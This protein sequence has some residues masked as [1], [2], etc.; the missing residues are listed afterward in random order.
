MTTNDR[1]HWT[2]AQATSIIMPLPCSQSLSDL[3][4]SF[5]HLSVIAAGHHWQVVGH[6]RLLHRVGQ[7]D[8]EDDDRTRH[9]AYDCILDLEIRN[10][11]ALEDAQ[12]LLHLD[13]RARAFSRGARHCMV[14]GSDGRAAYL[15]GVVEGV[16]P[17]LG[18]RRLDLDELRLFHQKLQLRRPA[19]VNLAAAAGLAIV[20]SPSRCREPH[21]IIDRSHALDDVLE[22]LELLGWKDDGDGGIV[23]VGLDRR[24]GVMLHLAEVRNDADWHLVQHLHLRLLDLKA[25]GRLALL[26]LELQLNVLRP[27]R[28]ARAER[29]RQIVHLD[30][31]GDLV[32]DRLALYQVF[33]EHGL[34]VHLTAHV[35]TLLPVRDNAKTQQ[36]GGQAHNA[37]V[38]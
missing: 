9:N 33:E 1:T 22:A 13:R 6:R 5:S 29:A 21:P 18:I 4:A 28:A 2:T 23:G 27:R 32:V 7:E 31:E 24:V 17:K 19:A 3:S 10:A 8:L 11:Q 16:Q 37:G 20:C 38:G 35:Q 25:Q 36:F 26:L 12:Q 34:L 14:V 15:V 30:E